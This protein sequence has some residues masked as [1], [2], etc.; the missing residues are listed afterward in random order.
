MRRWLLLLLCLSAAAASASAEPAPTAPP[1]APAPPVSD[2][3]FSAHVDRTE[4]DAGSQ[5]T[6]TLSLEG[7]LQGAEL[8]PIEFPK[9]FIALAQSQASNVSVRAGLVTKAL[10]LTYV[11]VAQEP[12]T[13]QLGPFQ[14]VQNGQPVLTDPI[15]VTVKQPVL[16][17]GLQPQQRFT[18]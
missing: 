1:G 13:F 14:V 8:Q 7:K 18:L 5:F 2:L 6:L 15:T 17:P 4:V 10:S 3:K 11:L 9:G 12:G 16:P